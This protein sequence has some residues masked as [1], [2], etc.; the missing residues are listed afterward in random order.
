MDTFTLLENGKYMCGCG[1][2]L[3]PRSLERHKRSKKHQ[4]FLGVPIPSQRKFECECGSKI[5]HKSKS[6]HLKSKK[7][8]RFMETHHSTE[9]PTECGVCYEDKTQF[10]KCHTCTQKHCMDCHPRIQNRTCPF[11][12]SSFRNDPLPP[13]PPL[14]HTNAFI[15]DELLAF[16]LF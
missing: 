16:L 14:E 9:T 13:P 3:L 4:K 2:V 6:K 8:L 5:Q 12:R 1:S 11:C 7:H 15:S 10:W